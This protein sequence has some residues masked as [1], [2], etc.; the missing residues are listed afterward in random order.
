[1]TKEINSFTIEFQ[2]QTDPEAVF[3]K[4]IQELIQTQINWLEASLKTVAKK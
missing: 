4:K 1:V 3:Q 2:L